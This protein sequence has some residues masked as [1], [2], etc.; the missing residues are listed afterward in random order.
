MDRLCSD[1]TDDIGKR[2]S[3]TELLDF[4]DADPSVNYNKQELMNRF[5]EQTEKIEE[6]NRYIKEMRRRLVES[7]NHYCKICLMAG[8]NYWVI[9][10][11]ENPWVQ[12]Y[13]CK[14]TVHLE[15]IN[16]GKYQ[17]S[18]FICGECLAKSL[19]DRGISRDKIKMRV[20]EFEREGRTQMRWL[21]DVSHQ[22][23]PVC[24]DQL[25]LIK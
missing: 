8:M 5:N 23:C 22:I 21:I 11:P 4:I 24:N 25:Q 3:I 14:Y 13:T 7:D 20:S 18:G 15:C 6:H 16:Q 1:I 2:L 9:N 19:E 17:S 10:E 12:L